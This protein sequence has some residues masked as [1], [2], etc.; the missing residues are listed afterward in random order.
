M[1]TVVAPKANFRQDD[2]GCP[3]SAT[4]IEKAYVIAKDALLIAKAKANEDWVCA[5]F[6]GKKNEHV[7]Y[8]PSKSVQVIRSVVPKLSDW[9]GAWRNEPNEITIRAD[10]R[11]R[12]HLSGKAIYEVYDSDG[13]FI[14]ANTGEIDEIAK[15]SGHALI[16]GDDSHPY[17]CAGHMQLVTG[18]LVVTD[19]M[20][21]GGLNVRFDGIYRKRP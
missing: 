11:G 20:S 7:G 19:N 5:W 8:L 18:H 21:C 13:K 6:F 14:T 10:N 16:F 2:V 1:A 3:E 4:C 9:S 12:L 17:T 15:P